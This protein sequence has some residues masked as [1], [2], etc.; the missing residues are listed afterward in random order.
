MAVGVLLLDG[1]KER[2]CAGIV[3]V[4]S[5]WGLASPRCRHTLDL[6]AMRSRIVSRA[7]SED[8]WDLPMEVSRSALRVGPGGPEVDSRQL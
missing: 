4:Q 7:Y 5:L 3:E 2:F 1:V 6:R 8:T